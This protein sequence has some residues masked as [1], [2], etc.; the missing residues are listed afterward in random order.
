[1]R[2]KSNYVERHMLTQQT[3]G[4]I[5]APTST[6]LGV[7]DLVKP[8]QSIEMRFYCVSLKIKSSFP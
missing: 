3:S 4:K 2:N 1:M 5:L 6:V 7:K 8:L